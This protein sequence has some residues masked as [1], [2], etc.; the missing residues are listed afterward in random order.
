MTGVMTNNNF[1]GDNPPATH[2]VRAGI[3]S[4]VNHVLFGRSYGV[5]SNYWFPDAYDSRNGQKLVPHSHDFNGYYRAFPGYAG[6]VSKYPD[7]YQAIAMPSSASRS[8]TGSSWPLRLQG[9]DFWN[10]T[11]S[12]FVAGPGATWQG[13]TC[14]FRAPPLLNLTRFNA[15]GDPN[16]TVYPVQRSFPLYDIDGTSVGNWGWG[17]NAALGQDGDQWCMLAQ[18]DFFF[19]L[20]FRTGVSAG[21][22]PNN[23]TKGKAHKQYIGSFIEWGTEYN[24][25]ETATGNG[26][27]K[28][29]G[30]TDPTLNGLPHFEYQFY[31]SRGSDFPHVPGMPDF[32][33]VVRS[34]SGMTLQHLPET[35][36]GGERGAESV[37]VYWSGSQ[38]QY[39]HVSW[40]PAV[41]GGVVP[42]DT[43]YLPGSDP[44]PPQVGGTTVVWKEAYGIGTTGGA[45]TGTEAPPILPPTDP[46]QGPVLPIADVVLANGLNENQPLVVGPFSIARYS[47]A[48]SSRTDLPAN[49]FTTLP[50]S[51][52]A[53]WDVSY[54]DPAPGV[55]TDRFLNTG[56]FDCL[57]DGAT[58][59]L[60]SN[61]SHYCYAIAKVQDECSI[62]VNWTSGSNP[63]GAWTDLPPPAGWTLGGETAAPLGGIQLLWNPVTAQ[64]LASPTVFNTATGTS[65][66][67]YHLEK[68]ATAELVPE[69]P[70][71][72]TLTQL[73]KDIRARAELYLS[74]ASQI[75]TKQA[76]IDALTVAAEEN[77]EVI[78]QESI[79]PN[80]A[81]TQNQDLIAARA[82]YV[83]DTTS[84]I[85]K[86]SE[87]LA[88]QD[89]EQAALDS[90]FALIDSIP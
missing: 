70:P 17:P 3:T 51:T 83:T 63:T 4:K 32:Q 87:L 30:S 62:S 86:S 20:S 40:P 42:S 29:P 79:N 19:S 81:P 66:T 18:F 76:D 71:A 5:H 46:G 56:I 2:L 77:F 23:G 59:T 50:S 43:N 74:Y 64:T 67:V 10:F 27:S 45:G 1:T 58:F 61:L 22:I 75:R 60:P 44:Y 9:E 78:I 14:F 7:G 80:I 8:A 48:L 84:I 26:P 11:S 24:G 36:L 33:D 21:Y 47:F 65:A 49:F 25:T 52:F 88:L 73:D 82:A 15:T 13:V 68:N 57:V 35:V 55:T 38:S 31:Y 69:E 34:V 72:E 6:P 53:N 41:S 90:L 28:G 54:V 12:G 16:A 37:E 39:P 85:T 89:A